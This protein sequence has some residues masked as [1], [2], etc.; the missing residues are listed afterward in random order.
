VRPWCGE[1]L[2]DVAI[3]VS[4]TR[5]ESELFI[6]GSPDPFFIFSMKNM[7]GLKKLHTTSPNNS[8]HLEKE[9]LYTDIRDK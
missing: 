9:L 4:W 1:I 2:P 7:S 5:R 8:I 3:K 6:S